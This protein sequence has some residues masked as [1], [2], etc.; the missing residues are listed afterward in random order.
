MQVIGCRDDDRVDLLI[1]LE[2]VEVE[3][4]PRDAVG[5]AQ[6]ID[7]ADVR[8]ADRDNFDVVVPPE[9]RDVGELSLGSAADDRDP[10]RPAH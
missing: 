3:V 2:I 7:L 9:R 10:D 6:M 1:G 8:V 4:V 5:P